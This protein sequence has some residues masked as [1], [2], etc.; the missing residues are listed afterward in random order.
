MKKPNVLII[1][2][3]QMRADCMGF[4]NPDII[5]PNLDSLAKR[6]TVFNRAYCS[7]PVCTPSRGS[8]LTG[9]Y[10]QCN[11]AW[12]IGVSVNESEIT[13][14]DIMAN[15]G[16]RTGVSGKTHYR[17]QCKTDYSFTAEDPAYRDR[18]REK[19]GTYYGFQTCHI[20]EDNSIGDYTDWLK[21]NAPQYLPSL[22]R[23]KDAVGDVYTNE[24]PPE[25]HKSHW[26]AQKGIDFINKSSDDPWMLFVSFV[27]PHH[28]F[29]P[30]KKFAQMYEGMDTLSRIHKKNGEH[31]ARPEH[32]R[33]QGDKGYWPGGGE[34][35]DKNDEELAQAIRNYYAMITQMDEEIGR[36]I[37]TLE[38]K[39]ELDNTII[40]FTADHGELLG[41]H[42]LLYKGPWMYECLVRIPM[43]MAGPG[44]PSALKTDALFENVDILPTIAQLTE[45]AIP[46]GV[47]G[48]SQVPVLEGKCESVRKSAIT[49]YDAHD[50]GIV[51]TSICTKDLKLV[52][53]LNENYGELYDLKNDSF[54][55]ENL[56]FNPDYQPQKAIMMEHLCHH[57]L[58]N[59]DP[60]PERKAL[61]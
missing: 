45:T 46:Y 36:V 2:A 28:P 30:S 26:I 7:S 39:N 12:N 16:Y 50:R 55:L 5:T 13:I 60:L 53:F 6:G 25:F 31:D 29:D 19:D 52:V 41:D 15:A 54:E 51:A 59:F 10:P 40:L 27:D 23:P 14:A 3:D 58:A 35:H 34:E 9:R 20:T 8:V 33:H 42:G 1:M 32:L 47:Q 57:L 24:I 21:E 37:K 17:P 22:G 38:D 43:I 56:F 48:V 4:N 11:G 49:I 44:I 18:A 61:W